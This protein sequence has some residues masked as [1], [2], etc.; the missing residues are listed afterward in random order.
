MKVKREKRKVGEH[1]ANKFCD[2]TSLVW[3]PESTMEEVKWI[4]APFHPLDMVAILPHPHHS[5]DPGP[6]FGPRKTGPPPP[7]PPSGQRRH[8]S[9]RPLP[10]LPSLPLFSS[11][12]QSTWRLEH[13]LKYMFVTKVFTNKIEGPSFLLQGCFFNAVMG[14]T[15]NHAPGGKNG[16][17][18]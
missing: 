14:R 3:T 2:P 4:V 7:P 12:P 16:S 11:I 17:K 8:G 9:P 5:A 1:P 15:C 13:A 6:D 18:F 10:P